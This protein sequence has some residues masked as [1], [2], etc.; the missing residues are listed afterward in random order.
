[1]TMTDAQLEG[2]GAQA[3]N[4]AKRDMEREGGFHFL[5]AS[6]HE[7][8]KRLHRMSKIEALITERLGKDWLNN[9]RT[10]DA[11]FGVLRKAAGLL[12]PDAMIF[13]SVANRFTPTAQFAQLTREEQADLLSAGHDRHHQA[14]EEGWMEVGDVLMVTVQ[15]R[16][17]ACMYWQS[18]DRHG[19]PVGRPEIQFLSQEYFD[20]RLKMFGDN[21]AVSE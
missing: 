20:G 3:A 19:K 10:K 7:E 11:G 5:L 14:V 15:T 18:I 21:R 6:Y 8:D 13:A 1:M 2:L 16:E 12:P 17:R 4:M 9:G